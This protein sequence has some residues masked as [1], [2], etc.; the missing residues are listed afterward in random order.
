[1]TETFTD[2]LESIF[3]TYEPCVV[4]DTTTGQVLEGCIN[5]GYI[6]SVVVF[7]V[8]LLYLLKTLGGVIHDWLCR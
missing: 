3:G 5:F 8:V 7:T 1:M 6:A 2:F 4:T